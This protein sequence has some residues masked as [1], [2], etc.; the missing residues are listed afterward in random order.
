MNF[1]AEDIL[2][3]LALSPDESYHCNRVLRMKQ[4][5]D[6]QIIDGKGNLYRAKIALSDA[7][8]TT[9]DIISA[10]KEFGKRDYYLHL[11]VAPTKNIDRFEYFVEKVVEIGTD[12][13]T[14]LN[15]RFSERKK[16]NEE[17]TRKIIVSAVKQSQKAYIPVL[18]PMTEFSEF[19]VSNT[20]TQ[21]FIAHC[22]DIQKVSLI[23]HIQS[24]QGVLITIGP[25]GDFS[26]EEVQNAEKQGFKSV[27]L[28]NSRLRT[29]TAG[30]VAA[31]M[32]ALINEL[33]N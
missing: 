27:S 30:V 11:A 12:C 10:E 28:G 14:P 31:N 26:L 16:I 25:E 29:E 2:E 22:Y 1:F 32:V 8:R 23:K 5:D 13:I 20:Q 21:K 4:G 18:N 24:K 19:I 15:C 6:I 33:Y 17:R 7:K 9:V 3:T